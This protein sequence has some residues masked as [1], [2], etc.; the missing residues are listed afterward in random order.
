M[1]ENKLITVYFSTHKSK[2][3]TA[4]AAWSRRFKL[5]YF[6]LLD[7]SMYGPSVF[8]IYWIERSIQTAVIIELNQTRCHVCVTFS[9][10]SPLLS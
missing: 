9:S 8:R 6:S 1:H 7:Q 2:S 5:F 10:S 4:L 3:E